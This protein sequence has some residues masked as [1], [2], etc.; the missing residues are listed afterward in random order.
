MRL[1]QHGD[2][3]TTLV[4]NLLVWTTHTDSYGEGMSGL[5]RSQVSEVIQSLGDACVGIG[6]LLMREAVALGASVGVTPEGDVQKAI[7]VQ[8]E[9]LILEH[10]EGTPVAFVGSEEQLAPI[11]LDDTQPLVVVTDPLDGSDNVEINAPVGS[12]FSIYRRLLDPADVPGESDAL[13]SLLQP[14]TK[15]LAAGVVIYGPMTLLLL[16]VG[17]GTDLYALQE[18]ASGSS[19]TLLEQ[20]LK[21]PKRC[22][23]FAINSSNY[24]HWPLGYQAYYKDLLAGLDGERDRNFNTRWLGALVAEALRIFLRGGIYLYPGDSR[25]GYRSG[26]LRLVYEANPIGML[27][28]QAGGKT[29]DGARNVLLL[30]PTELH[31]RVPLVFGSIDEV[32]VVRSYHGLPTGS[33]SPL[34]A[35][36]GFFLSA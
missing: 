8:S 20:G 16:T 15:Q 2:M 23:T 9:S 12:I 35:D 22:S 17:E 6:E 11:V 27:V 33:R 28:D 19:F 14:G 21:I 13:D 31:Q 32:D 34:F 4:D 10:L 30:K 1:L 29:T 26:R 3:A 25:H 18:H 36:R 24:R 5:E 7:D